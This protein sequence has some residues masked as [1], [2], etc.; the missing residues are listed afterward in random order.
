MKALMISSLLLAIFTANTALAGDA[1]MEDFSLNYEEVKSSP[2]NNDVKKPAAKS[3]RHIKKAQKPAK[4]ATGSTRRR[5]D[6]VVE[7]IN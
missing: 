4:G 2:Q 3:E 1:P 5:G 6:V 7:D